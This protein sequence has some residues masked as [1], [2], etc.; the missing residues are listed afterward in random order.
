VERKYSNYSNYNYNTNHNYNERGYN[1]YDYQG[2]RNGTKKRNRRSNKRTAA[3]LRTNDV[4]D[5]GEW[6][7]GN[8]GWSIRGGKIYVNDLD[9]EV[10]GRND[11][12]FDRHKTD[13]YKGVRNYFL[14]DNITMTELDFIK[15]QCLNMD[16]ESDRDFLKYMSEK[17]L[18]ELSL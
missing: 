11:I 16:D 12:S 14:N 7:N 3:Y 5:Y 1:D 4:D 10:T 15:E 6:P 18:F 9:N 17:S 13:Y 2:Y 8:S